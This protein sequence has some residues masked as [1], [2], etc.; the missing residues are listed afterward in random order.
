MR[1]IIE[2]IMTH[3]FVSTIIMLALFLVPLLIVHLLFLWD[4][5][6]T[7]L[8][9]K[10]KAGDLIG[11]IAGFEAFIGTTI[12]G[13]VA[14]WQT[15]KANDT[16]DKMLL[17]TIENEKKSVLPFLSFNLYIPKYEGNPLLSMMAQ[18]LPKDKE[19][20]NPE[21]FIPLEDNMRRMD[22]LLEE[23]VYS[24]YSDKITISSA[25]T[26]E[27]AENIRCNYST[28]KTSS[29]TQIT[30][31]TYYYRKIYVE[32]CGKGSAVNTKCRLF[33]QGNEKN[34][35]FDVYSISFTIPQGHHFDLGLYFDLS[36]P[37]FGNYKLEFVYH[38]I[39]ANAY[40]QIIPITFEKNDVSIDFYYPQ[41]PI[42]NDDRLNK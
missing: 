7:W 24:I 4:S 18:S 20:D 40:M 17:L 42:E 28:Q 30:A 15:E 25:L 11:Y 34:I 36:N 5:P 26:T 32:N 29:G 13:I 35:D 27:Q 33:L 9:A 3:K 8:S 6:C 12:L 39:Y 10:W 2:W 37:H 22:I 21:N 16:S 41:I 1:K 31:P 19:K 38:D 23:I 14:V